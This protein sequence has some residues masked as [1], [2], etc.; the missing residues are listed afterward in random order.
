MQHSDKKIHIERK[1]L[2]LLEFCPLYHKVH[3]N[4][5]IAFLIRSALS[6]QTFGNFNHLKI[7]IHLLSNKLKDKKMQEI[8]EDREIIIL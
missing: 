3:Q 1:V 4:A 7:N 8:L 5:Y 2:N 6:F